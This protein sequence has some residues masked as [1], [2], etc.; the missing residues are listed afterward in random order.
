MSKT[1][2]NFRW[3]QLFGIITIHDLGGECMSVTN[4]MENVLTFIRNDLNISESEM[5][6]TKIIYEDSD[7]I[8]DGVKYYSDDEIDWIPLQCDS[9]KE[10]VSAINDYYDDRDDDFIDPAGGSGLH[11]HV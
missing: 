3:H 7:G 10:A 6:G 8:W 5:Q 9:E 1:K 2:S 11:S 4:D